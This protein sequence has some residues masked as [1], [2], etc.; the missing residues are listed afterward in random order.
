ML[1]ED[2]T[3]K[4][5]LARDIVQQD[6]EELS[7]NSLSEEEIGIVRANALGLPMTCPLSLRLDEPAAVDWLLPYEPTLRITGKNIVTTRH[8]A[9][10]RIRGSIK[11]R[12]TLDDYTVSIEGIFIGKGQQYPEDDVARLRRCCEAAQV[13]ATSPLL[14][15]FGI[16][17]LVIQSWEIPHTVGKANQSYKI[18]AISDDIY[19]LLLS[20]AEINS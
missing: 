14:E 6:E 15:L 16:S 19:K 9:K 1:H 5:S 11:E 4:L 8:V 12:W 18:Q 20:R 7:L 10:G 2:K 3:H 13:I 17:R